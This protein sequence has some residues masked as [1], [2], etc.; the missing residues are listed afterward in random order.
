[1]SIVKDGLVRV[2]V[3]RGWRVGSIQR[4]HRGRHVRVDSILRLGEQVNPIETITGEHLDTIKI[5]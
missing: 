4:D 1:M 2:G 5:L 3:I